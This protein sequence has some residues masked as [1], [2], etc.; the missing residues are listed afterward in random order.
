MAAHATFTSVVATHPALKAHHSIF[1]DLFGS[2]FSDAPDDFDYSLEGHA[3]TVAKL[4][5]DL[6]LK[7]CS[8][9]GYSMSGAVAITLAALRP[10]LVSRL[11]LMEANLDPLG[12]GEG[13][14]STAIASQTEEEFCTHGFQALI[15][16]LRE[17]GLA[18]DDTMATLAGIFQTARPCALHRS[19]VHLVKGTQPTMRE[20]LLKMDIPRT[21]IFGEKSL[22][23]SKWDI[24]ARNGIRVLVIPN[25]GHGMAWDNPNGVAE[26]LNVALT[27]VKDYA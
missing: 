13:A 2:G 17:M 19:A 11:V 3:T 14:V 21:Y 18:G 8:I 25:A 7:D 20:R 15:N 1:I 26:A 10:D 4:L 22:P 16:S 24:L 6:N 5:D 23:D 9:I 12:P 27:D